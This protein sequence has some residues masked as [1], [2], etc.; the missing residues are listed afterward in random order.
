[1]SSRSSRD[2]RCPRINETPPIERELREAGKTFL[3]MKGANSG[4]LGSLAREARQM[5]MPL[6]VIAA[7]AE[8]PPVNIRDL[9][10]S[11][12]S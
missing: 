3:E 2:R 11:T 6:D 10:D 9:L 1:V 8:L 4:E 7:V 5:G 12:E